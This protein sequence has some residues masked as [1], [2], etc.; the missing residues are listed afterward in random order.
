MASDKRFTALLEL[1]QLY[2]Q[3]PLDKLFSFSHLPKLY[4]GLKPIE[5]GFILL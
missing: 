1:V 2:K 4:I 3:N 5:D